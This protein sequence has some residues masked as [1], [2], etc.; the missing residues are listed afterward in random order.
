MDEKKYAFKLKRRLRFHG[1]RCSPII[2]SKESLPIY[3]CRVGKALSG[4]PFVLDTFRDGKLTQQLVSQERA[5][6]KGEE[7][8]REGQRFE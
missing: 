7:G 1:S 8:R 5:V 3:R 2:H 4:L 6:V